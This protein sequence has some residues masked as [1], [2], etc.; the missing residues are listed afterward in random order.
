MA[1]WTRLCGRL[2]HTRPQPLPAHFHQT[3][4]G[5]T[6]HLNAGPVCFELILDPL[7]DRI[8]ISALFHVDKVDYDQS[9]KITQ[10]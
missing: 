8:V 3:K 6:P 5:Y 7:F 10:P 1:M 2:N 4:T 9:G